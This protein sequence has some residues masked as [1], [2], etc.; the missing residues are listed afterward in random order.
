MKEGRLFGSDAIELETIAELSDNPQE[1]I[2]LTDGRQWFVGEEYEPEQFGI[3]QVIGELELPEKIIIEVLNQHYRGG[4]VAP[5]KNYNNGWAPFSSHSQYGWWY[6]EV[7]MG[8]PSFQWARF[9]SAKLVETPE[10]D[11]LLRFSRGESIREAVRAEKLELTGTDWE[12]NQHELRALLQHC[13][14]YPNAEPKYKN[15]EVPKTFHVKDG[16]RRHVK[17]G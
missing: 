17:E 5:N 2:R 12:T 14:L 13:G 16:L 10:N 3:I 8:H 1:L 4:L 11:P 15:V 9:R 6:G 7:N